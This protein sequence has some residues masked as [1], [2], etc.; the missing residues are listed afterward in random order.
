MAR[1]VAEKDSEASE[2]SQHAPTKR[3]GQAQGTGASKTKQPKKKMKRVAE[4]DS[5]ASHQAE[6]PTR[7]ARHVAGTGSDYESNF[8][9]PSSNEAS[10]EGDSESEDATPPSARQ[11]R[12]G[13]C[14]E[15]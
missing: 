3:G 7:K 13:W 12:C 5:E 14:Q 11:R 6:R 2:V 15:M 1:H 9:D 4:T 8:E 10:S